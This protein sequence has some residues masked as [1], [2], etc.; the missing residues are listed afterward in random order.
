MKCLTPDCA[1]ERQPTAPYC[2]GCQP[3]FPDFAADLEAYERAKE[4]LGPGAGVCAVLRRAQ[5]IKQAIQNKEL[6]K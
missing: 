5:E 3:V 1:N 6:A 2:V 4:E